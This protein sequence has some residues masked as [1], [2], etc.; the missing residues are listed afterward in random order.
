MPGA[1]TRH[2]RGV[3]SE[4]TGSVAGLYRSA[5]HAFSKTAQQQIDLVAGLGVA[6]DAHSGATARHRSRVAADPTQ[7][8]LRQVH[9]VPGE[10]HD[11]LQAAGFD[12]SPGD[13]GENI[14]TRGVDLLSLPTGTLLQLGERA[15]VALTGLRNPCRQL[16]DFRP[17]LM[18]A[19]LDRS[20]DGELVRRAG[21]MGV[22]V[23]GGRVEVGD[24]I[25]IG[26]PPG[27]PVP[28]QPV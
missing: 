24:L 17:G 11:E 28:L 7:P 3:S 9:L 23:L 12:V 21:V 4:E 14:T 18:R 19:V 26:L 27:S 25:Q 8:N 22:V 16:D 20:S 5:E 10:L 15:L 2:N 6:G 1:A 13:I